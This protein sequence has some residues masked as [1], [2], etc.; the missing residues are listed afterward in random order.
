VTLLAADINTLALSVS[1]GIVAVTLGITA[2][3]AKRTRTA[4]DF[5]AA[6]RRISGPQNGFAI[7]GDYLS[8][9]AFLGAAG[10]MFLF[11][12]DGFLVAL[13]ALLTFVPLLLVA[14]RMRN[15]GKF[16]MAD[17]LAVRMDG[18]PARAAAALGTLAV[19]AVYLMAQLIAAG[20]V[21]QVLTGIS[22]TLAALATAATMLVYV[23]FGGMLA[24]T[25]V[26]IVK[27]SMLLAVGVVL[28]VLVLD[29]F[30][31]DP[32]RLFDEAAQASGSGE[33][34]LGPGLY[35]A[36]PIQMLSLGLA[37]VLGTAGLPHVL[38]RFLTVPDARA[39]RQSIGW[40]VALVGGFFVLLSFIGFGARAVLGSEAIEAVGGGGNL[41]I[42]V[43]AQELGGGAGSVG[44]DI[45]LAVVCGTAF[46]TILAVVA[47]LVISTS[48][49]VAH[50]LWTNVVRRGQASEGEEVVVGRI[51]AAS[52]SL[53]AA[54]LTVVAGPGFNITFLVS[55]AF[56]VAASANFPA[57]LLALTWRRFTTVGAVSG[58][59][60]GVAT[61]V[62]L[63]VLSPAVW[64]GPDS[65]GSP[66]SLTNPA[67]VSVPAGFLACWLGSLLSRPAA[68]ESYDELW[69]RAET[70][71]GA[72]EAMAPSAPR[73]EVGSGVA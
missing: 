14:E 32:I 60:V 22:F 61:S 44:G 36:E 4:T 72:E 59:V 20:V 37:F 70:G 66:V 5:W 30:G 43:L 38:M 15:A 13:F 3:A 55:L 35:F 17:V 26:Q 8:A 7:T 51:A 68:A 65:E 52:V 58:V 12:F 31:F 67:I 45:L 73:A 11:G 39:A 6:G 56:A 69:V 48:G 62:V 46:A 9:S 63:I 21:V 2:W 57:L 24:T 1:A 49:A 10:L 54:I 71:L 41:T 27:A 19:A 50:D 53:L 28:A 34:F 16:T 47:G 64:P 23:I 33:R 18:V 40:A 29:R 42:P 25:W